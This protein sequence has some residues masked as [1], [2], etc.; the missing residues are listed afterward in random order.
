MFF[1]KIS[2]SFAANL[3]GLM[4]ED[5]VL[6]RTGLIYDGKGKSLFWGSHRE[7]YPKLRLGSTSATGTRG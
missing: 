3:R 6:G 4:G 1:P 5:W 7:K 2:K